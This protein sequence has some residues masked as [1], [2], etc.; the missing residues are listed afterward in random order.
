[1]NSI[2]IDS[3]KLWIATD[4]ERPASVEIRLLK[5]TFVLPWSQFLYAEGNSDEIQVFFATHEVVVRGG[6][7]GALITDLSDHR[8]SLLPE[9][10]RAD[11]FSTGPK[12][13]ITSISV[14]KVE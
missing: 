5:R 11:R 12:T 14:R 1:M 8:V 6:S 9:P 7:L 3:S 10:V 4:H 2:S 13:R